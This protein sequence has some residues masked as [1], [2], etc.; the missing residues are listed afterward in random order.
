MRSDR[1]E[2]INLFAVN[3]GQT[4]VCQRMVIVTV[5]VC[6]CVF[7]HTAAVVVV[8]SSRAFN[9]QTK[10]QNKIKKKEQGKDNCNRGERMI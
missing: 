5:L 1:E 7:A 6:V 10:K 9:L 8:N 2:V 4:G 3:G